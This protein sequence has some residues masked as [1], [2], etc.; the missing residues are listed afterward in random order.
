MRRQ[1]R[2][3][4]IL[5]ATIG[6]VIIAALATALAVALTQYRRADRQ[7]S[8]TRAAARLC[9]RALADL[10]TGLKPAADARMHWKLLPMKDA[11][12]GYAWVEVAATS[13]TGRVSLVGLVPASAA[14][15]GK[16]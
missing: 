8:D 5:D 13:E 15:E 14:G 12:A 10:S 4:F 9:E 6:L 16:P 11:P 2:G 1:R 7:L 3:I